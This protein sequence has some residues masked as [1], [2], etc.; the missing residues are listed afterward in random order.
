MVDLDSQ[1]VRGLLSNVLTRFLTRHGRFELSGC[2]W[3]I[4]RFAHSI[5]DTIMVDLDS[6]PVRGLLS[7]LLTQANPHMVNLNSQSVRGSSQNY[8]LNF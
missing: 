3:C 8:S 2:A 6:Q 4:L 1:R 5:S 7:N